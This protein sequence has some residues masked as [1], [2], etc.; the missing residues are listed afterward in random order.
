MGQTLSR[1]LK[2]K[3]HG[4]LAADIVLPEGFK[5][6]DGRTY[7]DDKCLASMT[8]VNNTEIGRI[9]AQHYLW[10]SDWQGTETWDQ[11]TSSRS[12]PRSTYMKAGRR[13]NSTSSN[14]LGSGLSVA[15]LEEIHYDY[16]SCPLGWG[17]PE[18]GRLTKLVYLGF[19]CFFLNNR[20]LSLFFVARKQ[21]LELT[22]PFIPSEPMQPDEADE[23]AGD[24]R[25]QHARRQVRYNRGGGG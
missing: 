10:R 8:P 2:K 12:R 20:F 14:I 4:S 19:H 15:G 11:C 13:P 6:Q 7:R 16:R 1:N 22:S 5:W 9:N 3:N 25:P 24:R 18:L 21:C 23:A 17:H